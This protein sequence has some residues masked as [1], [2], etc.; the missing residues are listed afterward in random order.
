MGWCSTLLS[1]WRVRSPNVLGS[2]EGTE[3]ERFISEGCEDELVGN[4]DEV[5]RICLQHSTKGNPTIDLQCGCK[6]SL[7]K[8]HKKCAVTWFT[9]RARGC[10]EGYAC[11]VRWKLTWSVACEICETEIAPD[12]RVLVINSCEERL[13]KIKREGKPP[14]H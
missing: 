5:C 11:D 8:C 9:P 2:G 3:D 6:G 7:G 10:A 1:E 14:Y 4:E 12:L 13:R